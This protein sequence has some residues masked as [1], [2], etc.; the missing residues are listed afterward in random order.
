MSRNLSPSSLK[1]L[2]IICSIKNDASGILI[3]GGSVKVDSEHTKQHVLTFLRGLDEKQI[4]ELSGYILSMNA[5]KTSEIWYG[6]W[7]YV[8][9]WCFNYLNRQRDNKLS[10]ILNG[11]VNSI[12]DKLLG[13]GLA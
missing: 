5:R 2:Q 13:D 7:G 9:E 12:I 11:D 1:S 4:S 3:T 10:E 6:T 8:E